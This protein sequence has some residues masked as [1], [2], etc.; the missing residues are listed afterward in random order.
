MRTI[1]RTSDFFLLLLIFL[2]LR[3]FSLSQMWKL[4]VLAKVLLVKVTEFENRCY[5]HNE[6]IVVF[7][8]FY[9][10]LYI[11]VVVNDNL[12]FSFQITTANHYLFSKRR[13]VSQRP[14]AVISI[15][16]VFT[17]SRSR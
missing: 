11:S 7:F 10:R 8:F 16:K 2:T 1:T 5:D 15:D 13:V 14:D 17:D 6:T 4:E 12:T 3:S 9:I